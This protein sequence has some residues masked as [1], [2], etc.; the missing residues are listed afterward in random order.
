MRSW[1]SGALDPEPIRGPIEWDEIED[2]MTVRTPAIEGY[3]ITEL[4]DLIETTPRALR[5]YENI[6]LLQPMRTASG[7]RRYARHH[8]ETAQVIVLLRRFDV[9]I[10]EIRAFLHGSG[11]E[12]ERARCL[13]RLLERA[14][15]D[16]ASRLEDI[17]SILDG[18]AD[19]A[20]NLRA[21]PISRPTVLS[22][23]KSVA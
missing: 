15:R 11:D 22:A 13:R 2:F 1:G 18:D 14:G 20:T 9:G 8:H 10:E 4:A 6:G 21:W 16:L 19:V 17:R 7:G 23:S 12:H 3:R 5:Y